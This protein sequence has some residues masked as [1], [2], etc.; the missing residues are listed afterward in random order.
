[1]ATEEGSHIFCVALGQSRGNSGSCDCC[2]RSWR[3]D[4]SRI[5]DRIYC[6]C[7][8]GHAIHGFPIQRQNEVKTNSRSCESDLARAVYTAVPLFCC[9]QSQKHEKQEV[10]VLPSPRHDDALH[11]PMDLDHLLSL[12]RPLHT[13]ISSH[14]PI[15]TRISLHMQ[16]VAWEYISVANCL[17]S[18]ELAHRQDCCDL[19][20][21]PG[22]S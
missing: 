16:E 9:L 19:S 1:V 8:W 11:E 20:T 6:F 5:V 10:S 22:Q 18:N 21:A 3:E 12:L 4:V 2:P 14:S 13:H 7:V 15:R 17:F